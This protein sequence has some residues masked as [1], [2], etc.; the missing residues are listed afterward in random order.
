MRH[1]EVAAQYPEIPLVRSSVP[2]NTCFPKVSASQG[3]GY[4]H[5]QTNVLQDSFHN[6]FTCRKM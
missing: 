1:Q 2:S 6:N 5:N 4:D 3:I